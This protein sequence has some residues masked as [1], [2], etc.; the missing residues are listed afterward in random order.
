MDN[1]V[2]FMNIKRKLKEI[3]KN[4]KGLELRE[5]QID[6]ADSIYKALLSNTPFIL[7][8]GTGTGKTLA[9]LLA[10]YFILKKDPNG[11]FAVATYTKTL[12]DQ[13]FNKDLPL[14]KTILKDDFPFSFASAFGS[15]NYLCIY[16]FNHFTPEL[17]ERNI[18][19]KVSEWSDITIEGLFNEIE[20]PLAL[21]EEINRDPELCLKKRCPFYFEC[22]YYRNR[23]IL[24]KSNLIILNHHL[25]FASFSTETES[26]PNIDYLVIDEAHQI[27]DVATTFFQSELS[28]QKTIKFLVTTFKGRNS[29]IKTSDLPE[30]IVS[31]ILEQVSEYEKYFSIFFE[32]VANFLGQEEKIR[33]KN[34]LPFSHKYLTESY[35]KI[36]CFIEQQ[37]KDIEDE[38]ALALLE[39]IKIS[40]D[41]INE[42]LKKFIEREIPDDIYT[43]EKSKSD[44]VIKVIPLTIANIFEKTIINRLKSVIF[45]SATL[46]VNG[47]FNFFQSVISSGKDKIPSLICPQ[48]FDFK[49]N[50]ILYIPENDSEIHEDAFSITQEI[51]QL[52]SLTDGHAFVLFT[53]NSMLND[54]YKILKDSLKFPLLVQD[55][56]VSN[57]QLIS[58]FITIP[59]AVLLGNM[60]FW[61]GVDIPENRLRCVIIT[62]LPFKVPSDPVVEARFE[63]F[64]NLTGNGFFNYS[65]P[66]AVIMLKQ[67]FGRLVRGSDNYGIVSILDTRLKTR[68]YGRV[69]FS[70]LPEVKIVS[71][72]KEVASFLDEKKRSIFA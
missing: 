7:E 66:R 17:A 44:I 67:G 16:R 3:F 30:H 68:S 4:A 11:R 38:D 35:E 46:S 29:L 49:K 63:Y 69:F 62:R 70:S 19:E 34:S 71:D 36:T 48:I 60:S 61:Q 12:Q 56:S 13:I 5:P 20:I 23:Q 51:I 10:F 6:A 65:L 54:V 8:A 41:R 53:S 28:Y 1:P 18:W 33:V 40:F 14:L 72:L 32:E 47:E 25:L 15:N 58:K 64:E 55:N 52:T 50:V 57:Y 37:K 21:R 42:T 22:F 24:R 45:T 9:Y 27:E 2:F 39:K 43:I 59:N 31:Q 26:L